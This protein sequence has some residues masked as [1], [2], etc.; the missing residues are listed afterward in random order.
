MSSTQDNERQEMK[1]TEKGDNGDNEN[2]CVFAPAIRSTNSN[3]SEFV[4]PVVGHFFF[5]A[6]RIFP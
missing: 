2:V 1:M 4:R 5:A 3:Q 6:M